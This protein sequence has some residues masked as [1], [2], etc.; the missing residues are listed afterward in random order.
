MATVRMA[1]YRKRDI[2]QKATNKWEE[3]NPKKE[4]DSSVGEALFTEKLSKNIEKYEAFM[5]ENFP[6]LNVK[7]SEISEL[8]IRFTKATEEEDQDPIGR[9]TCRKEEGGAG[10]V[11]WGGIL[12]WGRWS[13]DW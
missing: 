8:S 6:E 12:G 13:G 7:Q 10:Q 4:Y 2:V 5:E 11:R 1:D 3:V 9:P